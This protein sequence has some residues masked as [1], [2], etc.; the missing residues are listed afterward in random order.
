MRSLSLLLI[1]AASAVGAKVDNLTYTVTPSAGD[2]IYD[3]TLTNT[4]ATGGTL[5]DLFLDIPHDISDINTSTIGTPV[6]WGDPTGG[7]LF[8]GPN[9]GPG[10]AFIEWAPMRVAPTTSASEIRSRAS[11]LKLQTKSV[12]LA[13]P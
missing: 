1:L 5:Y 12:Q 2:F 7:L 8:Y 10:T 6:G 3:F 9:T 13:S 4:G 11:R